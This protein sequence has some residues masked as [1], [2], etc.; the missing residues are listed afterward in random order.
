MIQHYRGKQ[1]ALA[2][3]YLKN[4]PYSHSND[5]LFSS[6]PTFAL[7]YL[8]NSRMQNPFKLPQHPAVCL[9]PSATSM[10]PYNTTKAQN[11]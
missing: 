5:N 3:Q 1:K 6:V 2:L 9:I 4:D 11:A 7:S 10:L 8:L